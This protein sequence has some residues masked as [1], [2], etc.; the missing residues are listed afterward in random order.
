[1][2]Q[3]YLEPFDTSSEIQDYCVTSERYGSYDVLFSFLFFFL[4]PLEK[5]SSVRDGVIIHANSGNFT[6]VISYSVAR[7]NLE[8][9]L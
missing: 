8:R 4:F 6:G 9:P 5:I 7:N 2:P 3:Q 1:M